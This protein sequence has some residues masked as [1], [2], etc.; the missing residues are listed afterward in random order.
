MR[1]DAIK[2]MVTMVKMNFTTKSLSN[3]CGISRSTLNAAIAGKRIR[4]GTAA[5]IADAL[6]VEVADLLED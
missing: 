3:A 1:L 2:L 5:V 4:P 6:G